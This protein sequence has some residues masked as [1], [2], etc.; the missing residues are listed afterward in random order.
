MV[1]KRLSILAIMLALLFHTALSVAQEDMKYVDNKVFDK[2][3]RAPALFEHD[4]HNEAS[5]VEDCSECHHVYEDGKI[6]ED[7]SSED[8]S[9]ADCHQL[10]SST[11]PVPL[12][13]AFHKNCKGCHRELGAG[14][15]M[16][17]ECHQ[18]KG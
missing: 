14:P 10:S 2:P 12:R 5:G 16:C 11:N 6:V 15:I 18:N 17:G 13:R 8:M 7:E 9:C 1:P 4:A 3:T